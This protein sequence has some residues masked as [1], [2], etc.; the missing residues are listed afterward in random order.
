MEFQERIK[1]LK[2]RIRQHMQTEESILK[3]IKEVTAIDKSV[4]LELVQVFRETL[5]ANPTQKAVLTSNDWIINAAVFLRD[6]KLKDP[7]E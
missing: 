7:K 2:D 5:D 3:E 4:G 1:I 6:L